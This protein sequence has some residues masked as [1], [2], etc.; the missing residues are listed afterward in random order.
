M[1]GQV[2]R[3]QFRSCSIGKEGGGSGESDGGG[4]DGGGSGESDGGEGNAGG[5]GDLADA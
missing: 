5:E 4:G 3:F 1:T 2:M